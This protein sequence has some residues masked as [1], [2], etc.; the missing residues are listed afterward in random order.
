M[1]YVSITEAWGILRQIKD[2]STD[3]YDRRTTYANQYYGG[4]KQMYDDI[5]ICGRASTIHFMPFRPD[6]HSAIQAQGNKD[7]RGAQYTW[8]VDQLKNGDVYV[9]NM[10]EAVLDASHVGDNLG[11]TI[12]TKS[13]NGAIIRG[14]VRDLEGNMGLE[15]FNIFVRD[16]RPESNSP[17]TNQ[18]NMVIGMNCPIQIGYIT[19]MPGDIVLAKRLGV[20]FIPPHLAR[21]VVERS[22]KTRLRDV[23][24]HKGVR[25]G[26]F[27]AAQADGGFTDA[28]HKEF[29]QWLRDNADTMGK[30]F[31]NP[32]EAPSPEFIR[33]Y[34]KERESGADN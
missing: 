1:K 30:F 9:A 21:A 6:V 5:T 22:E 34:V 10:C 24:A 23:F 20:V 11:T 15:G 3:T 8:G 7:G 18:S 19:V 29:T 14:T 17:G 2:G 26:R 32:A 12:F 13:G 31:K 4:F 25:E 28:M 16:F 27:T 33:A